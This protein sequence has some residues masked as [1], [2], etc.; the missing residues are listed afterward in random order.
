MGNKFGKI[1]VY[2]C[3]TEDHSSEPNNYFINYF[4]KE[5]HKSLACG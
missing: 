2:N 5:T 1:I 3:K 4:C